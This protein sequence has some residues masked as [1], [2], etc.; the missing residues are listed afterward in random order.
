MRKHMENRTHVLIL[1]GLFLVTALFASGSV[2]LIKKR[3]GELP[4]T[5][6]KNPTQQQPTQQA[7]NKNL[8]PPTPTYALVQSAQGP[9]RNTTASP[10]AQ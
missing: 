10:S 7:Q 4:K 8:I 6:Q 3:V 1:L 5:T 9:S 2:L